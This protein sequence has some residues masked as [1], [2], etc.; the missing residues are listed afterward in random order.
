[1]ADYIP[2]PDKNFTPR[3]NPPTVKQ[4]ARA[5]PDVDISDKDALRTL[6][7]RELVAIVQRNGGDIRGISAVR[8]LLDR[9]DGKPQQSII[10][11]GTV[12]NDMN[13]NFTIEFIKP[14]NMVIEHDNTVS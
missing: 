10:Q 5:T 4:E 14:K 7:M 12:T 11:S 2:A 9:V 13:V 3:R 1:M 6:A 8:E